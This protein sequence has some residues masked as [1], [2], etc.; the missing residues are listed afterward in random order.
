MRTHLYTIPLLLVAGAVLASSATR[1][2]TLEAPAQIVAQ[3]DGS[4]SYTATFR[5]GPGTDQFATSSWYG[6]ENVQGGLVGDCFCTPSCPVFLPG[7]TFEIHVTGQLV[8]PARQG[9]VLQDVGLCAS[10]GASSTTIVHPF[11]TTD[12]DDPPVAIEARLWNEP[13]PFSAG[14]TFHYHM[15]APGPVSLRV[16]DLAG[17]LVATVVEGTRPAGRYVAT[18]DVRSNSRVPA[19]VLFA[20]LTLPGRTLARTLIVVP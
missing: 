9:Q 5:K 20:R 10:P 7:A 6:V 2:D 13:N 16:Y 11:G 18:W 15:P 8:D 14:T 4:F 12:V 3:Q 17:R 19:G 1:A